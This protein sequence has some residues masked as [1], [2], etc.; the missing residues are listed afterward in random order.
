MTSMWIYIFQTWRREEEE[1]DQ[2]RSDRESVISGG[3]L[4][5]GQNF[6]QFLFR[7]DMLKIHLSDIIIFTFA[8]TLCVYVCVFRCS[9]VQRKW[10]RLWTHSHGHRYRVCILLLLFIS[11][12]LLQSYVTLLWFLT[13]SWF[14]LTVLTYWSTCCLSFVFIILKYLKYFIHVVFCLFIQNVNNNQSIWRLSLVWMK[15][16]T[17]RPPSEFC[18]WMWDL[19]VTCL[20]H[21]TQETG[22]DVLMFCAWELQCFLGVL[23]QVD[24]LVLVLMTCCWDWS[25]FMTW[26]FLKSSYFCM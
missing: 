12:C 2:W 19:H 15:M 17:V 16:W 26:I 9:R 25:V 8:T 1:E 5:L 18:W 13:L 6:N 4:F 3:N 10:S 20:H 21:H 7:P 14:L 23:H 22:S 11:F 24:V